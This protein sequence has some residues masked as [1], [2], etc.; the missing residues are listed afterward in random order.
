MTREPAR[1]TKPRRRPRTRGAVRLETL[2]KRAL[3]AAV[4]VNDGAWS[5]P[6]TWKDNVLPDDTQRVIIGQG[7]TVQLDL[8][9]HEAKELVI[10]GDLVALEDPSVPNKSVEANWIHVNSGGQFVVGSAEDRYDVGDFT[11][12]LKG[13][14]VTAD[15]L[16]PTVM[17]GMEATMPVHNND[18]FLMTG[19]EG[20]VQLYGED[21]LSFTKLAV[22]AKQNADEITVANL[23]ER[24]F[25]AG[26]MNGDTFETTVEDDGELNWEVGDQIV[27]ASSSYD[28]TE[29][30]VRFIEAIEPG[31]TTTVL[32]LDRPLDYRHYGERETYGVETDPSTLA[33]AQTYTIDLRAEVALLS[34]NIKIQSDPDNDQDTDIEFGDRGK[35]I[36]GDRTENADLTPREFEK[37]PSQ[38]VIN[39]VG[40]HVMIMPNSG[41]IEI[42]GVQLD[43]LGQASRKGRY[44]M[45]WHLGE[46]RE[47]DVFRNSSVTNSNN[48]GVTIH[49]TNDLTIEGIVLHDIHG[50]GFFFED[51]VETNNRLIGNLALGIHAVGGND[52]SFADPGDKDAFIVDT[53]D[54]V[55]ETPSRFASSAAFWITNPDNHFIGNIAAGAGDQ[56]TDEFADPG[57]AGTGFWYAIPRT[58]IG[59]AGNEPANRD[60]RPIFAEFGQF[61]Y[62]KSHTTA[63]GLN[64]D[65]GSDIEDARFRTDDDGDGQLD[66][67]NFDSVH[68]AN[69]YSPRRGGTPDG[70]PTVNYINHF[71]NYKAADAAVY[72]R[73]QARTIRFNDLRIADSYNGP[74]AVSETEFNRSLFVGHSRGNADHETRVGG[75]RLYDGAGLHAQVHFAGFDGES[76]FAFQVEG[77]S[78][79]PTMYHGF[80]DVSFENDGSY[81]H[82][83]HAIADTND[84][85]DG[86]AAENHNLGEPHEWIKA[87]IDLDGSLTAGHGGGPGYSIVPNVDFLVDADD[88]LL[89]GAGAYLTNDI[90]ARI[91]LENRNDGSDKGLFDDASNGEALVLFRAQDGDTLEVTAGQSNGNHSWAQVVAKTDGEGAVEG[92]FEIEFG[93][94]GVPADG[95]VLN[96]KNQD[97]GLPDLNPDIKA[98]V[99]RSRIVIKIIGA[100]NYTPNQGTLVE[101]EAALREETEQIVY[102]RDGF[103][104]LY[105]NT[106]ITDSQ[107]L[108]D[109]TPG[110]P[111][112]I[113]FAP[114]N[115]AIIDYGRTIQAEAFDNSFN[116]INGIGYYDNDVVNSLGSFRAET[117]VDVTESIVGEITDGEWLEYTVNITPASYRIGLNLASA[118]GDGEVTVLAAATNS[119]GVLTEI[120]AI[121]VRDTSG[122]FE[123]HWLDAADLT[124]VGGDQ[125]VIRLAFKGGGFEVDSIAFEAAT[126]TPY[127]H[128]S[129]KTGGEPDVI[130]LNHFD[131]GGQGAS[132]FDTTPGNNLEDASFRTDTDVEVS[133]SLVTN[134]V[135]EG[136]WL[137]YTVDRIEAGIYDVTLRKAWGGENEGVKLFV[138]ASNSVTPDELELIGEFDFAGGGEEFLTLEGVDLSNWAGDDRVFRIEIV[139]NYM[140]IDFLRFDSVDQGPP[141]GDIIDIQPNPRTTHAGVATVVFDEDVFGFDLGDLQL[142]RDGVDVDVS[143]LV[144]SEVSRRE[145][146]ID[147]SSVTSMDGDY[148]LRLVSDGSGI[149][150][151]V[152]RPLTTDAVDRFVVDATAPRLESV[153]VNGGDAQRS[154]V[155]SVTVTFS[156]AVSGVGAD[157]FILTNTTTNTRVIPD[158]TTALVDGKTVAT[159]T[160]SGS[161]VVGGS[162]ADG[163]YTLTTL[164]SLTDAAGNRL[165]GDQNGTGGD[166]ATA[167]FFR[168]FGDVN[169]DRMVNIVDFFRFRNA[170][171]GGYDSAFDFN[172]DG[173][174]NIVDFFQFRRRFGTS[175]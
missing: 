72:H 158:V 142:T 19:M 26:A 161:G 36:Y 63:V 143:D 9:T 110:A 58:G 80:Q 122:D 172:G 162:L 76:A 1:E 159:L 17:M 55:V 67:F 164:S 98:R 133:E 170:F 57:P 35:A 145:Y 125:S 21:R 73:G 49:G 51:A 30:E 92:T 95:F 61:D 128:R 174:I 136:E 56:R 6:N 52:S 155:S 137:E 4:A 160:F 25:N 166:D 151:S 8:E 28:Y 2:E 100:G 126:Q 34:R 50:H 111:L 29:E 141:V 102:F 46:G 18:G 78:F 153:M 43:G 124:T 60:V 16:I 20:R 134:D 108:I 119:A 12:T 38:Q 23:I 171:R 11:I 59:K 77:S 89:P 117:G 32:R 44:P 94:I 66:D 163:N 104:N 13:T 103:G 22:T 101:S 156:E 68:T 109:F 169:G 91:R 93:R 152:G 118:T 39:G 120:G 40:G 112:Q 82:L 54:S 33:A 75:P 144:F 10:Q 69:E 130:Y 71:T 167:E 41:D 150:D 3:L 138:G 42:D 105:L 121:D 135:L 31:E 106:G 45:H 5:D 97:G 168:L 147:L 123:M 7:V 83:V 113:P 154:M 127:V 131:H 107:P 15:H 173:D 81:D 62:N 175:A 64:F 132:Y 85:E 47:R 114:E 157:S 14:D 88:Q 165:D 48:R 140:G 90:Y 116:D 146:T 129:L 139:G 96:M 115:P 86:G 65:R 84:D 74:W 148:E 149:E 70:D 87:V 37:L 27:I 99:D 53:H 24:N 79:G